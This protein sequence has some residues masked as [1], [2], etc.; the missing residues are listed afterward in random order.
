MALKVAYLKKDAWRIG[1]TWINLR[2]DLVLSFFSLK[3]F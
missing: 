3:G 1:K 2:D